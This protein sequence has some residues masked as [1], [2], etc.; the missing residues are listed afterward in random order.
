MHTYDFYR[1][2][3]MFNR[4]TLIIKKI[5]KKYKGFLPIEIYVVGKKKFYIL[6]FHL[7]I[8]EKFRENVFDHSYIVYFRQIVFEILYVR[9]VS[10]LYEY[11]LAKQD[12]INL[13]F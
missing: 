7:S 5:F 4:R 6:Y 10:S 9:P 2:A 12:I 8:K 13:Q 1:Y 3:A 11:Q